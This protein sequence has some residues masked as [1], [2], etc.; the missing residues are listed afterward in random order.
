MENAV[1]VGRQRSLTAPTW[2]SSQECGRNSVRTEV[3]VKARQGRGAGWVGWAEGL[4]G[5]FQ[6]SL[7]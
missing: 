1:R 3:Q 4:L 5:L 6:L 7:G 2:T